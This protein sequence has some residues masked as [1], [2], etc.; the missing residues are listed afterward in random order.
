MMVLDGLI[1]AGL[2]EFKLRTGHLRVV[3]NTAVELRASLYRTNEA[4]A[5]TLTEECEIPASDEGCVL[6]YLLNKKLCTKTD[7]KK[8]MGSKSSRAFRYPE[9]TIESTDDVDKVVSTVA[10]SLP[11]I[12]W[13][14]L[15]LADSLVPSKVG[16]VTTGARGGGTTGLSHIFDWAETLGL[17]TKT[18]EPSLMASLLVKLDGSTDGETWIANPYIPSWERL[19]VAY[20]VIRSDMDLFPFLVSEIVQHSGKITRRDATDMFASALHRVVR[21]A[22]NATYLTRGRQ[23]N[24]YKQL[25]EL[26]KAARKKGWDDIAR[27]STAWHRAS[28]RFE[29]YVDLGLLRK[30]SE[31]K[32][33]YVYQVDSHLV[34][35]SRSL[36]R[37]ASSEQWIED[38]LVE[39]ILRCDSARAPLSVSETLRLLPPI[40][41]KLDSP[42]SNYP[43]D[44]I[45]LGI[46]LVMCQEG[47]VLS[48]GAARGSLLQLSRER[49]DVARLSRGYSGDRAEY[50]SLNVKGT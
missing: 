18:A 45:T 49:S 29:T 17:I 35:V 46:V 25:S 12:W 38:H 43:I 50:I 19:V 30:R 11:K 14:D 10:G 4:V 21:E 41:G 16:A 48:F 7:D 32:F 13:Q 31:D 3:C 27:T 39:S 20:L 5:A 28:S 9:I 47:Q 15:C 33:N 44:V 22:E 6:D 1:T 23:I 36:E 26:E 24:L 2:D 40:L 37:A 8:G 42:V 34:D